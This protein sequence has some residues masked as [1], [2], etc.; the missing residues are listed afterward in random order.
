MHA[1][2][3]VQRAFLRTLYEDDDAIAPR[4][5]GGAGLAIYRNNLAG[6]L[7]EALRDVYPV[8]ERLVGGDFFSALARAYLRAHPS[9]SGDLHDYGADFPVFL[10]GFPPAAS[11]LYLPDTARLEWRCHRVF[12]AEDAGRLPLARIATIPEQRYGDLLFRLNPASAL[13]AADFPV[14]RIW[15]VNQPGYAGD[16]TV[17]LDEG[18]VRLLI[19]RERY[20][21][22][23]TR[24]S[25]GAFALLDALAD[26]CRFAE[27]CDAAWRA[28]TDF[29][30]SARL[31]DFVERG[32]IVDFS[33][34]AEE[35][36][37]CAK[38]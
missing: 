18:A 6:N 11:L 35:G 4:L 7:C 9:T 13:L 27:A 2:R 16:R 19:A 1:L 22:M 28:E 14:D 5:A 30:V 10:A 36:D 33:I 17:D 26:R 31:R 12:H 25:P 29:D 38:P 3:D 23:V 21:P 32:V 20:E 15:T 34:P 24:L 37:V 8:I